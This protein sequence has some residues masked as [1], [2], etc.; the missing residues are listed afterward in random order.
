[1]PIRC[2]LM[3]LLPKCSLIKEALSAKKVTLDTVSL[4]ETEISLDLFVMS[5]FT[6]KIKTFDI[7]LGFGVISPQT[8]H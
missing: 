7:V 3:E 8:K 1:M 2:S 6:L 4:S 5:G